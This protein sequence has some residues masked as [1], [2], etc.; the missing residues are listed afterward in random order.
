[1]HEVG[2][3]L[4]QRFRQ[5]FGHRLMPRL[6]PLSGRCHGRGPLRAVI[7]GL[8]LLGLPACW[9]ETYPAPGYK[10]PPARAI[11]N[12]QPVSTA[13][14]SG[15]VYIAETPTV[16]AETG[17]PEGYKLLPGSEGKVTVRIP[18]TPPQTRVVPIEDGAYIL[19]DLPMGV[20]LE[21]TASY[22][23]YASRR[24]QVTIVLAAGRRLNFDHDPDGAGTYLLRLKDTPR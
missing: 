4:R 16:A 9:S 20:A 1:M 10:R 18:G 8:G 17:L 3:S 21:V 14:L 11:G 22:P 5:R 24:Q 13:A 19:P 15:H 7:L 23:G 6:R 12:G 2:Q